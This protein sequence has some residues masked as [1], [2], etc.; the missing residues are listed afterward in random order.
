MAASKI[1]GLTIELGG[2][3]TK[4][5]KALEDVNKKGRDLSSELGE[6]NRLLKFDPGNADLLAQKQKVLAEQ[7]ANTA[8]KL[9]TLKEAERQVQEQF[10]RG[11]A[12]EEQVRALQ[13]EI[14]ATTKKLD[15][16]ENAA[17]ETAEAV[18]KL[19]DRSGEVKDG[20]AEVKTGSDKAADSFDDYADA[21]NKAEEASDGLGSKL[22]SLAKGG[23]AAIGA[24][25]AATVGALVGAAEATR[26]YRTEMGKLDTAFETV[27][28]SSEDAYKTYSSL[29]G[30]LGETDQAV[31]AANHLAKLTNNAEELSTWTDI[32][33]GVYATFGASLPI[34]G[35]TEAANETAKVGQVTGPLADALNWAGVSEDDFNEK[36][37][38][39]SSEQERQ[40][41]IMTTLNGLYKDAAAKYKETNAEVIR[42]NQANEE[43]QASMADIGGAIEPV[44]TDVKLLGASLLS[45]LVPGVEK[46][47]EAFRGILEGDEGAGDALGSALSGIIT[48]SLA[49]IVSLAPTV[50]SIGTSLITTLTTTLLEKVPDI[51]ETLLQVATSVI[52]SLAGA[53]PQLLPALTRAALGALDVLLNDLPLSIMTGLVSVIQGIADGLPGMLELLRDRLPEILN[54]FLYSVM[55]KLLEILTVQ[56]PELLVS[57]SDILIELLPQVIDSLVGM[58]QEIV[59][60]FLPQA[61]EFLTTS[62]PELIS[63]T[64]SILTELLP[65][66]VEAVITALVTAVPLLLDAA[67]QLFTAIVDSIPEIVRMLT[68]TLP[69]IIDTIITAVLDALPLLLEAAITLFN[70]IIEAIPVIIQLLIVELPHIISTITGALLKNIP[71]ILST[72]I[73]LFY[74]IIEA[75]PK[76]IPQLAK[77]IPQI[78][79]TILDS[80]TTKLK[81]IGSIGKNLVIGL[82]NG[83]DD[84]TGW[85]IDKIK[86]FGDSILSG[87]KKFFGI[88]S[89]SRV[90][91]KE[92]G[93]MLP[94]GE[95]Q[96]IEDE[97]DAPVKAMAALSDDILNEADELNGLTLERQLRNTFEGPGTVGQETGVLVALDKIL[98]AIERGQIIAIDGEALVG[99]TA[100]RFDR[101]LGQRRA[102]V[103]RGAL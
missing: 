87:I 95:A 1:K 5:G 71:M 88:N 13:R 42:A 41:L 59:T 44:L 12:S 51:L 54:T 38:S 96:G 8:K 93:R 11:E 99:A 78:A 94:L 49:T 85:V 60:Q 70:A 50:A 62:L 76:F 101:A 58:V 100:D 46:V 81:D 57:I 45:D 91:R 43:W 83:I 24:A 61:I 90:M 37:A 69:T 25:A 66:V 75:I 26:E 89:P 80:L 48:Q 29:Q 86:G 28:Y 10:Q 67:L 77:Q 92:V 15:G 30:V 4:L 7:I 23:L 64:I 52:T 36:L 22:G 82:W 2:D 14:V 56:L 19:G 98:A 6:I 21:A 34:E 72:A 39:C 20:A 18:E 74:G 79:K 40:A 103:A 35:L 3:T 33:T 102:L 27:G 55:P 9:D 97:A 63:T 32:C 84:M 31:E 16:Y 65:T 73:Q 47:A 68:D 53:L 17:K